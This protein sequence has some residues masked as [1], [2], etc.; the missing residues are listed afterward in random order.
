MP[1]HRTICLIGIAAAVVTACTG[2][3]TENKDGALSSSAAI[4]KQTAP[5]ADLPS[6]QK[7]V[8]IEARVAAIV[9]RDGAVTDVVIDRSS[10]SKSLDESALSAVRAARFRPLPANA[11][12]ERVK[13]IV[14]IHFV[15]TN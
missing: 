4:T 9:T 2:G 1:S 7:G 12:E 10:G 3:A 5:P 13:V 15:L 11:K 6:R 14:P 8:P